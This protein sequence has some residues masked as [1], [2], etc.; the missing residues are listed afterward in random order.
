MTGKFT[1]RQA[2]ALGGGALAAAATATPADAASA[3]IRL[4]VVTANIGRNNLA[5]REPAIRDVRSADPGNRPFVGW[6][7]ISEGDDGEP[8]II[9]SYFGDAFHNAFLYDAEAHRVPISVPQPWNV[10]A[11]LATKVHGQVGDISPPRFINEVVLQHNAN[12]ALVFTFIN[13]HYIYGAYNGPQEAYR[14]EYWD[15][16][17][18]QHRERVMAHNALGRLVIWTA[19]TN[20]PNYGNATGQPNEQKAFPGDIDRINWL[21]GNGSVQLNL[22][23]TKVIPMNVDGHNARAAIFRIR[24]V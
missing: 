13:T 8:A 4:P 15:M 23:S 6:Q 20:N 10:I 7:E 21:P 19:D 3:W 2:L 22:L 17:K 5:A 1:R 24:S 12:P 18:Q 11:R 14:R 16:L 9:S